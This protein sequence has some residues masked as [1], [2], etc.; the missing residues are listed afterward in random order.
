MDLKDPAELGR[1]AGAPEVLVFNLKSLLGPEAVIYIDNR[2][3]R[4]K[5]FAPPA[6]LFP[7]GDAKLIEEELSMYFDTFA[8]AINAVRARVRKQFSFSGKS[9]ALFPG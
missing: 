6:E 8:Q 4:E 2:V 3:R 9:A 5:G 1:S 7:P